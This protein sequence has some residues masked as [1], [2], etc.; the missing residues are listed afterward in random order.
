[1]EGGEGRPVNTPRSRAPNRV[2]AV[3]AAG[4]ARYRVPGVAAPAEAAFREGAVNQ[5]WYRVGKRPLAQ[6]DRG[7]FYV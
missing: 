2:C 7:I 6:M 3:G 1:M 5:R 4:C